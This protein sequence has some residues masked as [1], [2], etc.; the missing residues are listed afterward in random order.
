MQIDLVFQSEGERP[1]A[2]AF[3]LPQSLLSIRRE[4][5]LAFRD[6][7]EDCALESILFVPHPDAFLTKSYAIES[8]VRDRQESLFQKPSFSAR[9]KPRLDFVQLHFTF[10]N[11]SFKFKRGFLKGKVFLH[12]C[13]LIFSREKPNCLRVSIF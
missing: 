7:T 5:L 3:V 4:V 2:I 11:F 8:E 13:S 10:L 6:Q 1:S 12:N 9:F